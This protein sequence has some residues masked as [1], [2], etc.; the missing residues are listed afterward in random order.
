MDS[1]YALAYA[2]LADSYAL[3]GNRRLGDAYRQESM[4]LATEA[5]TRALDLDSNLAEAHLSLAVLKYR[6]EWDRDAAEEEFRRAIH[7]NP[8]AATSHLRYAMYLATMSRCSDAMIEIERARVLDP[9]SP[10]VATA[11]G[12]IL[13]FQRRYDEAIECH[14]RALA[15]DPDF[16]EA[17]FNL[18]MIYEQKAM[19]PQAILEFREVIRNA[20][21]DSAFW[22]AGLGH[23]YGIA[24]I[25]REAREILKSLLGPEA[26]R[27]GVSPFD[28]GWVYLGLGDLENA[29][30]WM[31]EALKERC[32][33]L[34]YQNVEPALDPLRTN[35]RFL[36]LIERIGLLRLPSTPQNWL[37]RQI[38]LPT[39]IQRDNLWHA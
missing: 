29:L 39:G 19:F 26:R 15:I 36:D 6:Y 8:N 14:R 9:L 32:G 37:R 12:R 35:G 38:G 30:R 13:H 21:G 3:I 27:S 23:A 20:D 4:R 10:I 28:V 16:I 34:V 5:A 7:L 24:G 22:L 2:G 18:G 1:Q 17:H 11:A 25:E 33:A 31:E